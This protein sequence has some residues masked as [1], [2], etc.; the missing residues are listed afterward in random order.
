M[1][2]PTMGP[3]VATKTRV[4]VTDAP[5]H[6]QK[7][8]ALFAYRTVAESGVILRQARS[9]VQGAGFSANRVA[10]GVQWMSIV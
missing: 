8:A 5:R 3:S 10:P 1:G 7:G 9:W 4:A 2:L 6:A